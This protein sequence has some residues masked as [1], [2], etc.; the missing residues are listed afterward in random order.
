MKS[1]FN[2]FYTLLSVSAIV[3]ASCAEEKKNDLAFFNDLENVKG[4]TGGQNNE[5]TIIKGVGHSGQY[6]SRTDSVY[7]YGFGFKL[8]LS[9]LSEQPIKKIKAITWINVSDIR[10][11]AGLVITLDSAGKNILWTSKSIKDFVKKTDEW[12]EV[13]SEVEFPQMKTSK[14]YSVTAYIWNTG[15]FPVLSDDCSIEFIK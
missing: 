12:T 5:H 4:W 6:L 1:Q 11:D 9:D 13:S 10:S 2:L 7:Q 14:D 8:N 3:F 15:K